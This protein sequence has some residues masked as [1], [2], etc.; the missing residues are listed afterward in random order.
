M[1]A[2]GEV[3]PMYYLAQFGAIHSCIDFSRCVVISHVAV[4]AF[5]PSAIAHLPVVFY[6][7]V[8]C[9]VIIYPAYHRI[10]GIG[11]YQ[12]WVAT[13]LIVEIELIFCL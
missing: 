4:R 5:H 10:V 12:Y 11:Y 7:I 3:L 13:Y 6:S 2:L 9:F 1:V 8:V